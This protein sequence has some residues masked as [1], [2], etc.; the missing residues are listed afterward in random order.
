MLYKA[1]TLPFSA[2]L[3]AVQG[4]LLDPSLLSCNDVSGS[5]WW[6]LF[7]STENHLYVEDCYQLPGVLRDESQDYHTLHM[8]VSG[9]WETSPMSYNCGALCKCVGH[10]PT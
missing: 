2:L 4:S 3:V 8:D 10:M 1:D 5:I 7:Q 9:P 6:L